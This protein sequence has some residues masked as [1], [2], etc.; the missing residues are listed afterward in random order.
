MNYLLVNYNRKNF[1]RRKLQEQ[2]ITDPEKDS[3]EEPKIISRS[4][5]II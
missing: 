2:V 3:E 5:K 4:S 1:I